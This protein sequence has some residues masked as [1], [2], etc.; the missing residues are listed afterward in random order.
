ME[1][2]IVENQHWKTKWKKGGKLRIHGI[3]IVQ[4]IFFVLFC[5]RV[6]GWGEVVANMEMCLS[7]L[8]VCMYGTI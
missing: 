8:L 4:C 1:T 6:R 2:I 3:D 5:V 7:V